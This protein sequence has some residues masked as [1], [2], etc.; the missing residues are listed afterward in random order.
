MSRLVI[1][2]AQGERS[3]IESSALEQ[4]EP[5]REVHVVTVPV[6]PQILV[7]LALLAIIARVFWGAF[8]DSLREA[9]K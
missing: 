6:L 8:G 5:V 4:A 7:S 3:Y 9:L 2:D 1:E